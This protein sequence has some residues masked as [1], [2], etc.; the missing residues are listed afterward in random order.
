MFKLNENYE[1]ERRIPKCDCIR[2]SPAE[3]STIS[4]PI[5]QIKINV[6]REDSVLSLL[7][8]YLDLG[9]EVI[10][11][12]E[13]SRYANGNDIILINLGRIA[14]LSTFKLTTSSE[15]HLEDLS[16][17]HI[18]S[19][20]Y[21]ILSSSKDS[22]VSS[23]GFDRSRNRRRE[24]L[25]QIKNIKCKYHLKIMLREVFGFTEHHE[26]ATYDLGY[27]LT[28]T[29]NKDYS[30]IDKT[31]GTADARIK[32]YLIHWYVAQYIPFIQ[33]QGILSEQI[34]NKTPTEL[35]YIEL[36]FYERSKKSKSLEL[37][38]G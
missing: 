37:R 27:K 35:R 12:A 22:D 13:N 33:Q 25:T 20:L 1:V 31:A 3:T 6:P 28:L 9:F 38:I 7:N 18:V 19:L 24:E 17:A 2:Y 14:Q 5:S 4:I 32:I 11:K 21:K 10:K 36:C 34:L 16:H 29:T 30:V 26:K 23:R 8:S 15:K